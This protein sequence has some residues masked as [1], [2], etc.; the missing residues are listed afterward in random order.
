MIDS[1]YYHKSLKDIFKDLFEESLKEKP[2]CI[3]LPYQKD[4]EHK[5][6]KPEVFYNGK[7]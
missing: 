3:H 1:N 5:P 4:K 6:E 7:K 2:V